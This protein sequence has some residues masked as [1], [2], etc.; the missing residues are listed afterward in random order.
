MLKSRRMRAWI[1][2][3][4]RPTAGWRA[5]ATGG[6]VTLATVA[7][8]GAD[9]TRM[10]PPAQVAMNQTVGPIYSDDEMMIF[11][12]KR[13][14]PFPILAPEAGQQGSGAASP[15]YPR[16]P[17]ITL[18][19]VRV[20]VSWMVSNLDNVPRNVEVLIDPW[21]E[22]GRYWPGLTLIDAENGE[23]APN[24][25]GINYYYPLEAASAGEGSRRHGTYTY[26]D[27]DELARDFATVM[28]LIQTPPTM[29]I[30]GGALEEGESLLPNYV[31]H[32]FNFQNHSNRDPLVQA[33]V[34]SVTAGLTGI[35]FGLRSL[36]PGAD[37]EHA[38]N[39]AL[40]IVVEV[41][42]LGNDK[43]RAEG[44]DAPLLAPTTEI[45]TIGTGF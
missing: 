19:D 26:D 34:P 43:V 39:I 23:Y 27:L 3:S 1:S 44:D 45:I 42:D 31:N 4:G 33:W 8:G 15:P 41:T 2:R 32:A 7:C 13:G 12:V 18:D 14:L 5:L 21:T 29:P 6:L 24:Q 20:Q 9:E 11:E 16:A 40:E 35:D 36:S 28:N 37:G 10:L 30:G 25:S 22:F 17:W 38:P